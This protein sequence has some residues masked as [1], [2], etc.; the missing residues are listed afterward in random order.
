MLSKG[1]VMFGLKTDAPEAEIKEI[2]NPT[3]STTALSGRNTTAKAHWRMQVEAGAS[4]T[5]LKLFCQ[6]DR[7]NP[8]HAK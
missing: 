1:E 2:L 6:V 3:L 5:E 4:S 8:T 7:Q